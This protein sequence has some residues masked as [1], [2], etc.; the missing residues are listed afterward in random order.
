[1]LL[2]LLILLSALDCVVLSVSS[3]CPSLLPSSLANGMAC[4][5]DDLLLMLAVTVTGVAVETATLEEGGGVRNNM[6]PRDEEEELVVGVF[7][8]VFPLANASLFAL[9]SANRFLVSADDDDDDD[10]VGVPAGDFFVMD[11]IDDRDEMDDRVVLRTAL[12]LA[13]P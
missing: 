8:L 13:L 2:L 1:M 4:A 11:D 7:V 3:S 10:G 5:A 12:A 6:L 9:S